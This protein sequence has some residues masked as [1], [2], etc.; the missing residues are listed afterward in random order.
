M[1]TSKDSAEFF[2]L[3]FVFFRLGNINCFIPQIQN[4]SADIKRPK[5]VI[6]FCILYWR[7]LASTKRDRWKGNLLFPCFIQHLHQISRCSSLFNGSTVASTG[8]VYPCMSVNWGRAHICLVKAVEQK[9]KDFK[10]TIRGAHLVLIDASVALA[11]LSS[12]QQ[13]M[14]RFRG[15]L[16]RIYLGWGQDIFGS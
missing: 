6:V 13:F 8:E 2:T 4:F 14:L 16:G 5:R 9:F 12:R 3:Y 11:L 15:L 1:P 10:A 7:T